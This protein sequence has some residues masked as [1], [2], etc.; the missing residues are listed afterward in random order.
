V[1][2]FVVVAAARL[3]PRRIVIHPKITVPTSATT[4]RK[5]TMRFRMVY[6]S[7]EIGLG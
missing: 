6:L 7:F 3:T 5:T 4:K 1:H 2:Q